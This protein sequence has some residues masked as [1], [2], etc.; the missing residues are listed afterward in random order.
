MY[1]SGGRFYYNFHSKEEIE[2]LAGLGLLPQDCSW[3]VADLEFQP[4]HHASFDHDTL[5][6]SL[7]GHLDLC[8]MLW[9]GRYFF[10]TIISYRL[11]G[12]G[13]TSDSHKAERVEIKGNL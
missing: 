1:N 13:S 9:N 5:P 12:N 6:E 2:A 11:R 10:P 3:Q 4:R 7:W 8:F